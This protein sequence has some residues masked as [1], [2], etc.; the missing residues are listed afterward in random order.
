MR[1]DVDRVLEGTGELA[2]RA[3]FLRR[4]ISRHALDNEV[5]TGAL[6]AFATDVYGRPWNRDEVELRERA[7]LLA[8]GRATAISHLSALRRWGTLTGHEFPVH[9]S[10]PATRAPRSRDGLVVHRVARFPAVVR[11]R[12]SVTVTAAFAAVTSWPLLD[13]P[14]RRGPLIDTV[15]TRLATA[16]E[17]HDAIRAHPRLGG[18]AELSALVSLLGAGCESE[19]EIWGHLSVFDV[20]GLRQ[21]VRQRRVRVNGRVFR[22]DLAYEDERVAVELDGH[23]FHSS[24]TQRDRDMRRDT[25]L[26]TAGWQTLRYSHHR[27]HTDIAGVRRDTL[28]V[29]AARRRH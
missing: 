18:R 3:S 14:S 8:L 17:L 27:L 7:V 26:A 1:D 16:S 13:A 5:R 19:L 11:L 22:L 12:G 28:A 20:A 25:L 2:T 15:R 10:V 6:V 23:R 9:V 21:A 4:G 29:L 24:V